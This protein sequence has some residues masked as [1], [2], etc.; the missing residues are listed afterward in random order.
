VRDLR[1]GEVRRPVT[2]GVLGA[3]GWSPDGTRLA[4]VDDRGNTE[5]DLYV[6]P[7]HG[8]AR[9]VLPDGQPDA[10]CTAGAGVGDR[11]LLR[12]DAGREFAGL[13][14]IDPADGRIDWITAPDADVEEF[15]LSADRRVLV[16]TVNT[17]G[18]SR[19]FARDLATGA[20]LPVPD[21]PAGVI[22]RISVSADGRRVALLLST[23]T[24]PTNV[25]VAHL[26]LDGGNTGRWQWLTDAVPV[27]ATPVAEPTLVDFPTHDGRRIPAWL[28]RPAGDGP[29][30]VVLS[31]HGGPEAQERPRYMYSGLYQYLLSRGIAVLAPNV[32]GSTGYGRS[33]QRLIHRDFGGG[34]LGDF[35]AAVRHLR[36][37]P[38]ADPA[39]IAVFGGSFGGFASLS[40]LS[41][42][43]AY[44]ACGVSMMGMSNLVT[45]AKSVPPTWR[46]L[47]ASWVGDPDAEAE[48]LMSRS[49]LTYADAIRAP[50][51][52]IQGA[53]DPRV[54]QAESDQIVARL[55]E[56]GVEVRYDIYPDEGHGFTKRHNEVRAY[57]DVAAFLVENLS[58]GRTVD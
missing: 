31:I 47:M 49:P 17:G 52:V 22:D 34:E 16:W 6:V 43:P 56:R 9:R 44:W 28:Y 46:P 29:F 21:Q 36:D 57:T 25:A 19:L 48:F 24:R 50:L 40:C 23:A 8:S 20:D 26:D 12:T 39:R 4:V 5:Q 32:R 53:N 42:L 2:G 51:M 55:R 15:A 33:Y 3:Q 37:Q 10:K 41:R 11:F 35:E 58:R 45:F 14:W 1:T 38:W 18:I 27:A 13:G 54:V 7:L 30:P